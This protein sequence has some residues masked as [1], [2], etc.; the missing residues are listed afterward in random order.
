MIQYKTNEHS[1]KILLKRDSKIDE[2]GS[3]GWSGRLHV[4]PWGQDGDQIRQEE[5]QERLWEPLAEHLG[6]KMAPK[7]AK[8]SPKRRK[9]GQLG[10]KMNQDGAQEAAKCSQDGHLGSILKP[11]GFVFS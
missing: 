6:A 7:I 3:L 9:D 5:V 2:N 4:A 8:R 10:A 11:F 1:A